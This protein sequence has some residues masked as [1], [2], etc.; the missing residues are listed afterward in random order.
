MVWNFFTGKIR[1]IL[2][3][4]K[5]FNFFGSKDKGGGQLLKFITCGSCSM[6]LFLLAMCIVALLTSILP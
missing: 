6:L 4:P 1:K 3:I 5:L 2:G